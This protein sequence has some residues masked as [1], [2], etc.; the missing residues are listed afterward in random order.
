M[1]PIACH[2]LANSY[3]VD[4]YWGRRNDIESIKCLVEKNIERCKPNPR[5]AEA[6]K[7]IRFAGQTTGELNIA[8]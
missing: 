4:L 7:A 3:T 6:E 5:L 1:V 2:A 8:S